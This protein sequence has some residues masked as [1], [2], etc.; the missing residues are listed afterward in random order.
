MER[1]DFKINIS[2]RNPIPYK[3]TTTMQEVITIIKNNNYQE[4][5]EKYLLDRLKRQ[6]SH[7]FA[8]FITQIPNH[9]ERYNKIEKKDN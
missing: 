4:D 3:H 1:F 5:L 2:G 6:P 8:R 9:I 7:T